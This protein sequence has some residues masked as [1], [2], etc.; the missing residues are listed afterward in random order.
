MSDQPDYFNDPDY[1]ASL[2]AEAGS[3]M[4]QIDIDA[5]ALAISVPTDNV[6]SIADRRPVPR[7]GP[8]VRNLSTFMTEYQPMAYVVERIVKSGSIYTVTAKTGAGKTAWL[9]VTSLA[10]ASGI[11]R[12]LIGADIAPGRVLYITL[13]NP[14]DIRMRFKAAAWLHNLPDLG[15]NL[16]VCHDALT[17]AELGVMCGSLGAG[18][19]GPITLVVVDTLQAAYTGKDMNNNSEAVAFMRGFRPITQLPGNPTVIFAAH[20]PKN[21][22]KDNLS[23]YGAGG[24]LNEI[25]GNL[26]LENQSGYVTLGWQGKIRGAQFEPL[27]YKFESPAVP[28]MRD[29][30]GRPVEIPVL[31]PSSSKAVEDRL[32]QYDR[33]NVALLKL[34]V[35]NPSITQREMRDRLK[36]KQT[37][38]SAGLKRLV[39]DKML[40]ETFGKYAPTR[41]ALDFL[42][43]EAPNVSQARET[44][45]VSGNA[46]PAEKRET[47]EP[48]ESSVSP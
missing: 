20:P 35:D 16:M 45:S 18:A 13:E 3:K 14:D 12:K 44:R 46:D 32:E 19:L 48:I 28:T 23:Q 4:S 37:A 27:V 7:K 42:K 15:D 30:R 41:R 24:I 8:T 2:E 38:I 33:D 5:A 26:I 39:S 11:G 25:D 40:S 36:K 9:V 17:A 21:A 22:S 47:V 31:M 6:V 43:S 1:I 29:T 34:I 10:V